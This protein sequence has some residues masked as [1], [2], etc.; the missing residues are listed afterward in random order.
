M[1]PK[2]NK[3]GDTGKSNTY[4][5]CQTP[6]YALDPLLPYLKTHWTIWESAA[7][8]GQIVSKLTQHGFD[9]IATDILTG[10]NFF[11]TEPEM[12][13]CQVTNPPYSTKYDWL[14]R[15]YAL[16][17]PFALLLP[18][19]TLGTKS[20]QGHFEKHGVEIILFDKRVNF[21]MP[22]LGYTGSGAQFSTAWFTWGLGIGKDLT[23]AK[24]SRYEDKQMSLIGVGGTPYNKQIKP[25]PR[26]WLN[27][28]DSVRKQLS[29]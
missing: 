29:F 6:H 1:K 8:E 14:E 12:W 2:Q 26:A 7:G 11:E 10:D 17:R 28:K 15:S 23:F 16:C 4:D 27:G 9:V 3:R 21:K 5:R 19:E 20:G 24:L 22:N 25:T 13:Q 18:L